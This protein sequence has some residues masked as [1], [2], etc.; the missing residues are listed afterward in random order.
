M[1]Y[2]IVQKS[3]DLLPTV[4]QL[5]NAF[6][7]IPGLTSADAVILGKDAFGI[8][9]KRFSRENAIK[10]QAALLA[11]GVETE[12]VEETGIPGLPPGK[13]VNRLDCTPEALVIY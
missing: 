5:R 10:L 13:N 1:P 8:V 11:Q 2:A 9:V 6:K 3:L 7:G 4:E 12:V